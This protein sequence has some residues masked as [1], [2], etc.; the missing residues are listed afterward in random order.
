M[1]K[2]D[3]I[4]PISE[5]AKILNPG[6]K[7]TEEHARLIYDQTVK[8]NQSG[9]SGEQIWQSIAEQIDCP[10][11]PQLADPMFA[12]V[13]NWIK[14]IRVRTAR[15]DYCPEDIAQLRKKLNPNLSE[16]IYLQTYAKA[17]QILNLWHAISSSNSIPGLEKGPGRLFL[18]TTSQQ[19]IDKAKQYPAWRSRNESLLQA[20]ST[21]RIWQ[22]L[23]ANLFQIGPDISDLKSADTII[24]KAKT[25][26]SWFEFN[27][28]ALEKLKRFSLQGGN[29]TS[30]PI[31]ICQLTKLQTLNLAA[32]FLDSLPKNF[33]KLK[34]LEKL[35]LNQ[36]HFSEIPEPVCQLQKL[37]KLQLN[38][39]QI[40]LIP[41]ELHNLSKLKS[42]SLCGNHLSSIPIETTNF[43]KLSSLELDF[44]YLGSVSRPIGKIV[45]AT[46][47][48]LNQQYHQHP[49]ELVIKSLSEGK[50]ADVPI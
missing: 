18:F 39:N 5:I 35:N 48:Q 26:S 38:F 22:N 20:A 36:N 32:N 33:K 11:D 24:K 7:P 42:L 28:K 6:T 27:K 31:E 34:R 13:L 40:I 19:F 46:K 9:D 44:N 3:Y 50:P 45:R 37:K 16:I 1:I 14:A 25:F 43:S 2:I 10:I 15:P 8:F 47:D 29:L 4:L 30:L 12:Q 49:T 17:R 23:A 21:L 41:K